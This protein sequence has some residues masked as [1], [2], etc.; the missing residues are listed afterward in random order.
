MQPSWDEL[1]SVS[2]YSLGSSRTGMGWEPTW[3]GMGAGMEW[4]G[5]GTMGI[6]SPSSTI[7]HHTPC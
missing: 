2:S 1:G 6:D 4:D 7:R 3:H 5:K